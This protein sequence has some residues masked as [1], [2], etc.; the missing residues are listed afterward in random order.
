MEKI[1]TNFNLSK[2]VLLV[3]FLLGG[4][5]IS[6][7]KAQTFTQTSPFDTIYNTPDTLEWEI[8]FAPTG[9][10]GNP[11][12][13]LYFQ[14]DF[15]A[16]SETIEI[17][18]GTW[19]S[20]GNSGSSSTGDCGAL[21]STDIAI[22][23]DSINLWAAAGDTI[24]FYGVTTTAVGTF[25]AEQQA[26]IELTY[27]YCAF[28]VPTQFADL[29]VMD[30]EYC[31]QN[32]IPMSGTP[33]GGVYAGAGI[34]GSMFDGYYLPGGFYGI[35]YTFTDTL[36]CVSKDSVT[37]EVKDHPIGWGDTICINNSAILTVSGGDSVVW[38]SDAL[39]TA[40]VNT[41][42]T[43]ATPI[44]TSTT[45][46]YVS[47]VYNWDKYEITSLDTANAFVTDHNAT[48]GDDRGGIAVTNNYIY[49]VGDDSTVRY[50]L[51]LDSSSTTGLP[52]RD[53]I[54]SN[55]ADGK[56]YTLYDGTD[57]PQNSPS[58][59]LFSEIRGLTDDLAIDTVSIMLSDTIEMGTDNA[60]SGIFAGS[61]I[62][63]IYSGNTQNWYVID[64][65]NGNVTNLGS[66]SDPEFF[67]SENWADWGV[68]EYDNLNG[69][70][71]LY[72]NGNDDNI[73]RRF[74]PN[75]TSTIAFPFD[76]L[77]DLSSFTYAPW[78]QR[79]YFHYESSGQFGG[80]DETVGYAD[81]SHAITSGYQKSCY[82]EIT[83]SID[84]CVSINENNNNIF[85]SVS[86]NPVNDFLSI[87][88]AASNDNASSVMEIMSIEGR[89]MFK[90]T[91]DKT[92]FTKEVNVA[93]FSNGIYVVKL[94]SNNNVVVK[95]FVKQ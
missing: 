13:R 53:G 74:L 88:V 32:P 62:L 1:I 76:N 75:S 34:A 10:Y 38:F 67:G 61:N 65:T 6:Q 25:C 71:V 54:F 35:S 36:G 37:I 22:P 92:N 33:T 91:I 50:N 15:A 84:S 18:S 79:W 78:N 58:F 4:L 77:S 69:Y 89:L 51:N 52:I 59:F 29:T 68:A 28:G 17:Y 14:G 57:D 63:I 31:S 24:R 72:R 3:C 66:I 90:E 56:L 70:S 64:L 30:T 82:Q 44:L 60:M 16:S 85:V 48:S 55:L 93:S 43:F 47:N 5:F 83:V 42:D 73:H 9:A 7:V 11:V 19:N 46:Y 26:K 81:A 86:P 20:I 12:L 39:L 2:K 94:T 95:K 21:V 8:T 27:D 87:Q 41:T 23:S 80:I 49:V 45:S 40:V